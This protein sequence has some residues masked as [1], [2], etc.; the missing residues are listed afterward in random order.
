MI[1]EQG[2]AAQVGTPAEVGGPHVGRGARADPRMERQMLAGARAG[3]GCAAE[4]AQATHLRIGDHL[5][6]G[7]TN[8]RVESIA[9]ARQK[10]R[11]NLRRHRLWRYNHASHYSNGSSCQQSAVS[12]QPPTADS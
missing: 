2:V 8:G 10:L 7:S 6:E 5:H 12:S 11:P 4:A 3:V 1:V 9:A